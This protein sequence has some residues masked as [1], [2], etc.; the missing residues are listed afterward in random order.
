MSSP[1]LK[2]L[3]L[4]CDGTWCGREASTKTNIY[5]LAEMIGI[6]ITDATDEDEH[7]FPAPG[8][9]DSSGKGKKAR[10]IHGVGLGSTFLDYIFNGITA[11]D[12]AG[13]CIS[14]YKY[15]VKNYVEGENEIWMFGLSRGAYTVR[16]VGGMIN[17]CGIVKRGNLDDNNL[18][19]LCHEVYR[20][21]RSPYEIDTPHS[22]QS[23]KF[24]KH[25]SWPLIGDD[26]HT[27][28]RAPKPPIRFMGLFDTV[29]ELGIP[30]FTG[31]VG[32]DWPKFYDEN[33]SSVVEHVHQAAS[34]HDRFYIFQPC[35]AR[36]DTTTAKF[37]DRKNWN[38]TEKWFPGVHYDLGRQR[39]KFFRDAG[40]APWERVLARLGFISKV[41]EPNYVLADLALKWMLE[42]IKEHDHES[43]IVSDVDAEIQ[44]LRTNVISTNRKIGD[45]DVYNRIVEY[46]PFGQLGMK[47]WR[48]IAGTGSHVNAVYEL[49][50]ALRDRHIP[51]NTAEVYD[52]KKVDPE[53]PGSESIYVL[54]GIKPLGGDKVEDEKKRYP[55]RALEAWTLRRKV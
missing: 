44:K 36:R 30:T 3:I 34:L 2:P 9:S 15:I 7:F 33:I 4:L 5:E 17:N 47:V 40:G 1:Q 24:R 41:I 37:K 43:L 16:C 49:L 45:G 25:A 22:E 53:L 8:Q 11:Q 52:Y 31:G 29:G 20:I 48:T 42:A 46:A 21:Y 18:D 35:L 13:Q 38:I 51:D 19:L 32:L 14:A 50:F 10:Y 55:S 39:F 26:D 12:I 27:Q 54:A 28:R 6:S 23:R